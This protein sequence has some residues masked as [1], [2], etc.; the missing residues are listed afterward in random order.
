MIKL[1]GF[2][3]IFFLSLCLSICLLLLTSLVQQIQTQCA[4]VFIIFLFFFLSFFRLLIRVCRMTIKGWSNVCSAVRRTAYRTQSPC[5][6]WKLFITTNVCL[7]AHFGVLL[8]FSKSWVKH[9]MKMDKQVTVNSQFIWKNS[10]RT[11]SKNFQFAYVCIR[12]LIFRWG[13]LFLCTSNY[14]RSV[15]RFSVL[16]VKKWAFFASS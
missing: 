6:P 8:S 10:K 3:P 7:H 14:G 12:A 16:V 1:E 2:Q 13:S 15:V 9:K 11:P 5:A 4:Q